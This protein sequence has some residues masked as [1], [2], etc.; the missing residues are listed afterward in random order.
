EIVNH[1]KVGIIEDELIGRGRFRPFYIFHQAAIYTVYAH[2]ALAARCLRFTEFLLM[3]FFWTRAFKKDAEVG[4]WTL[5]LA[6]G[7]P[8]LYNS[9]FYISVPELLVML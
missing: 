3:L 4:P 6:L 9:L 8:Y 2:S 1:F 5:L 7:S